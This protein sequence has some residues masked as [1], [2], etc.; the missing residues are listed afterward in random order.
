MG[1]ALGLLA[2]HPEVQEDLYQECRTVFGDK[3]KPDYDDFIKLKYGQAVMFETLRKHPIVPVIPKWAPNAT[4]LDNGKIH[5]PA[6]TG[7]TLHV[8]GLHYNEKYWGSDAD[9]FRPSRFLGDY[10]K[11]A[12]IPFSDGARSCIGKRF[13][14]IEI[15]SVL[16][17][18]VKH[19]VITT[20]VKDES[21][22]LASQELITVSPKNP[23]MLKLTPR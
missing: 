14:Q 16:C 19:F 7:I 9:K 20:D 17:I 1:F 10:N 11:D 5:V 13:A 3:D 6:G 21:V 8:P 22:L 4:T 18:L 2:L 23:V 15:V 12:F